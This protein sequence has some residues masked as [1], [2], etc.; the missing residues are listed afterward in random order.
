ML[1]TMRNHAQGWLA[2]LILGGIALSFVLWGVGDYFLGGGP[3]SVA[4]IDGKPISNAEYNQIYER[5]KNAYRQ[6][7]GK[8]YSSDLMD[9]LNLKENTLQTLVNR[10]IML[11]L[12]AD[13]GLAAPEQAVLSNVQANPAFQSASGFDPQR[14]QILT[15]NMGFG[16]AQDYE[17]D[18]R[19]SIMVDALQ[20]AVTG[21]ARVS[22]REVREAFN[23]QYEQRVLEA[24]IVDPDSVLA[25][26]SVDESEAQAWYEGHKDSYRSPLRSKINIVDINPDEL[27]GDISVDEADIRSAY[28]NRENEFAEPEQR[29]ASHIL[30]KVAQDASEPLRAMAREKIEAVQLR[31]KSGEDFATVAKEDSD[32]ATAVEGGS[33]GWFK[34]DA[35]VA[36]F[37]QVAFSMSKGDTS[38]IIE[39]QFGY[40]I[41]LLEDIREAKTRDFAEVKDSLKD[42][43]IKARAAE[44]A[45]KLSQDLDEALGME[46]SLKAAADSINMKMQ[47]I[48]PLSLDEAIAEPLLADAGLRAKAFSTMPGQAIEIVETAKGHF[49]AFEVIERIEPEIMEFATVA[50]KA[51]EDAKRD[52]AMNQARQLAEDIRQAGDKSLDA[53]A[54]EFG[55]A[56]FISKPVRSSGEGDDAGWLTADVLSQAFNVNQGA[57]VEQT[58]NVPQG[59][60][61]VR[62]ADVIA[63]SEDEF[64]SKKDEITE[65]AERAKGEMRFARWMAS[66]RDRHEI[67]INQQALERY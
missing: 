56:K 46:D 24:I 10:H 61:V 21:S 39:S 7:F 22:E 34:Q 3:D 2:K 4:E 55:Q 53:M 35:M 41:I 23:R 58:I 5:Q 32:D 47:T 37:G 57:W 11:G 16:S 6:M 54:Q 45:Y 1:E 63:A 48:D 25:K 40:H 14:Y 43:L 60:A 15:R 44:E 30:V 19:L 62:V 28:E 29:K 50:A 59:F 13:L 38:D 65:Q 51:L 17:N 52:A 49:V 31:L 64:N 27:A 42:D 9:S 20:K 36:A 33:I 8:N 66:V 12:A 26:I 67:T 18:I